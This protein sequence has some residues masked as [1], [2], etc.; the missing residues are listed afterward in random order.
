MKSRIFFLFV[1]WM[2]IYALEAQ[3]TLQES[4]VFEG[5]SR[6]YRIY[7][8]ANYVTGKCETRDL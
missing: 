4:F 5:R 3:M 2:N 8:P 6:T 1:A 7:L